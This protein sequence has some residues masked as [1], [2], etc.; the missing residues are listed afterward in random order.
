MLVALILALCGVP[1]A[2][3]AHEYSLTDLGLRVRKREFV[4]HLVTT[5][6]FRGDRAAA[7]RM[8]SARAASML[9]TLRAVRDVWG[10]VEAYV[11]QEVGLS[12]DE[13]AAVRRNLVVEVG[14]G[15]GEG[16]VDWEEHAKLM[17]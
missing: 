16:L 11:R 2:A 5:D 3:V 8:V 9:G 7:E 14:G 13:V 4:D 12:A 1:D 6:V 17:L 10:G 15:E